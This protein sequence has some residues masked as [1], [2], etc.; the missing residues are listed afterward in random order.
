MVMSAPSAQTVGKVEVT[1]DLYVAKA[2]LG[3]PFGQTARVTE[4]GRE[5][6]VVITTQGQRNRALQRQDF[7]HRCN[8]LR[9]AVYVMW[10]D[11]GITTVD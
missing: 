5:T 1:I 2:R 11:L 10:G 9:S 7:G 3:R 4:A 8:G 6:V